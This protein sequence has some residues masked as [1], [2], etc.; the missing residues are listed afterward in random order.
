VSWI[1]KIASAISKPAGR[2]TLCLPAEKTFSGRQNP[3]KKIR[4][5]MHNA[6]E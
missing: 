6:M 5:I 2:K 1:K 3:N 4:R